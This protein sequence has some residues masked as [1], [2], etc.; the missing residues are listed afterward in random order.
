MECKACGYKYDHSYNGP[1][2]AEV[3]TGDEPFIM[4]N[5]PVTISQ[6]EYGNP[7]IERQLYICPKCGTVRA[8]L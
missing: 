2:Y 5:E 6:D 4:I 3:H 8:D 1:D 7:E